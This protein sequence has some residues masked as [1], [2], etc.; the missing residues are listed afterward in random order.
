MSA[1]LTNI[2]PISVL[3]SGNIDFPV[4]GFGL[5]DLQALA[6]VMLRV[7]AIP[8]VPFNRQAPRQYAMLNVE[9]GALLCENMWVLSLRVR[10]SDYV[11][12]VRSDQLGDA[13]L[14]ED[15]TVFLADFNGVQDRVRNM[16]SN[17]L[18]RFAND[19]HTANPQIMQPQ[20]RGEFRP[21]Q[22]PDPQV[23]GADRST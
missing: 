17:I 2:Y 8:L 13:T 20:Q 3:A 19:L 21:S 18:T 5:T 9:L 4:H 16:L 12:V 14:W 22:S 10:L 11:A 23:R 6:E 15:Y 7:S 1:P